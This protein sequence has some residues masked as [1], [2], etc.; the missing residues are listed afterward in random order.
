MNIKTLWGAKS[1]VSIFGS[2]DINKETNEWF[3]SRTGAGENIIGTTVYFEPSGN[4][5]SK[6]LAK[7]LLMIMK[8]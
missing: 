8:E 3:I 1:W 2:T 6:R 7:F 5:C 4:Y